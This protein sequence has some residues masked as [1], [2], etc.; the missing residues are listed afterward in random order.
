MK[1]LIFALL[2]SHSSFAATIIPFERE[3]SRIQEFS[4]MTSNNATSDFFFDDYV[5][6]AQENLYFQ[7]FSLQ[8]LGPNEIVTTTPDG[9]DY[10][11]R[12]FSFV[13][14]DKSRR[15]TYLWLTDYNG[16]GRVSDFFETMLVFLPREN[17]MHIEE[18]GENLFVTLTTGE[19]VVFSKTDKTIKSGVLAEATMDMNPDRDLRKHAQIKY[20]GKGL[21]I[22]SDSR[23]S[24]PTQVKNVQIIKGNLPPCTI[25]AKIFWSREDFPKFQFLTDEEAYTEISKYCGTEYIK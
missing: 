17:L 14:T 5:G 10:P 13:S 12:N 8:N 23:G 6:D 9:F 4:F 7:G 18:N 2:I 24:D 16:S 1:N 25:P 19:E 22:R 3:I 21:M 11:H 20:S 15:D